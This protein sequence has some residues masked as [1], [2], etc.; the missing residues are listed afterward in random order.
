MSYKIL[1]FDADQTLLDFKAAENNALRRT[2]SEHGIEPTDELIES[3]SKTN[4]MLWGMFEKGEITKPEIIASRFRITAEKFGFDYLPDMGFEQDYQ[5]LLADEHTLMPDAESVS[6]RLS[7]KYK[8]YIITNGL[9]VTQE[10][11]LGECGLLPYYKGYFV[12]EKMGAQKPSAEYFNRVLEEIGNPP[13]DEILIIGDS[14]SSDILGGINS[15]LD[16]CWFN[17]SGAPAPD[18]I[19]PTYTIGAL[20][21]LYEILG[22]G[23]I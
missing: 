19:T 6:K 22:I 12:S 9:F 13:K 8:M 23:E 20:P 21:E 5:N 1:L 17:P 14:L 18:A 16:T 4:S 2:F 15:G 3:F 10:K 11:R 7:E